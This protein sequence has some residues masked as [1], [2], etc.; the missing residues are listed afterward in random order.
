MREELLLVT[1][2]THPLAK[3][4][5]VVPRDLIGQPFVLFEAGSNSRRTHRGVLRASEQI[6][7]KVVTETENVEIIKALVMVGMGVAIIPYQAVAARCGR[8]SCSA[9]G[10]PGSNW[11][12][13][14]AGCTCG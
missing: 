3:S 14:P 2:P 10:L 11:C 5:S 4:A 6:A 12:A 7:P 1:A 8:A 9:R 13:R